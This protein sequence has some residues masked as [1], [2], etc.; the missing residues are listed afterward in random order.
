LVIF[1][2]ELLLPNESEKVLFWTPG[3]YNSQYGKLVSDNACR[4]LLYWMRAPDCA[5]Q[6]AGL[7]EIEMKTETETDERRIEAK[8]QGFLEEW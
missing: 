1:D 3:Q 7:N 4:I 8:D 2:R 6:R 5:G